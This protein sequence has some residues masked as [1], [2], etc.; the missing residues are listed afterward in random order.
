MASTLNATTSGVTVT[1]SSSAGLNL[2]VSGSAAISIGSG[3]TTTIS[4][5]SGV[6]TL[7]TVLVSNTTTISAV[8][9]THY[10]LTAASLTT[11]TLPASPT[12]SDTIYVTVANGLT[13]NVISRN[14]KNIQGL[15]ENMTL[16]S[17]YASAQLR[18]TNDATEGWVL[19]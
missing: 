1:G 15:A 5:L 9:G 12:I 3:G 17:P 2:L 19:A 14:G 18:F 4:N 10:V 8:V 16:D 13:T 6:N 11:V 7:P